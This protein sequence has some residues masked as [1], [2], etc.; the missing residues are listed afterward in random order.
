MKWIGTSYASNPTL[1]E[2]LERLL[3][4]LGVG[5]AVPVQEG[6]SMGD[7]GF[8]Q[9]KCDV[10][11]AKLKGPSL[12]KGEALR[13]LSGLLSQLQD[14][15][16]AELMLGQGGLQT[17]ADLMARFKDDEELFYAA[18]SAFLALS[19]HGAD[20]V[21]EQLESPGLLRA[22]C[23]CINAHEVYSAPM[24]LSDLTRAIAAA[25]RIKLK[26]NI[27]AEVLKNKPLDSL[28][29]I[30]TQSD[31]PL[32]RFRH[33]KQKSTCLRPVHAPCARVAGAG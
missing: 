28:M 9:A 29:R 26:P 22:L 2:A 13:M 10:L 20:R 23:S 21:L 12:D 33:A 11:L 8:D 27:V 31:D 14:P 17:L 16:N 5:N 1:Q 6:L 18:S 19:E 32:V 24:S 30:M 15:K 3:A 25:A 7:E 4:S